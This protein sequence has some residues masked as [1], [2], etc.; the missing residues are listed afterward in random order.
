MPDSFQPPETDAKAPVTTI[1]S[2]G[3]LEVV[4]IQR[5]SQSLEHKGEGSCGIY[6]LPLD[7]FEKA[8]S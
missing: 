5:P 3:C 8:N 1:Y 2:R 6:T 7:C 4:K